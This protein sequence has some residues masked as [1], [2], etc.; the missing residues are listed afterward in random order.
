M[1]SERD[2]R[3]GAVDRRRT[4]SALAV[5]VALGLAACTQS[6]DASTDARRPQQA[7]QAVN[8][9]TIA[10]HIAAARGDVLIGDQ[11]AAQAQIKAATTDLT[12]SMRIP[13]V[14]RPIDHE[15]ARA[16]VRPIAGVRTSL[17]LDR[18]NFVVMV[19]AQQQRSMA[20]IDQVCLA[21]EPL[22]DTLAVVVNV[23]D[24]TAKTADGATTLSRNCQL[25]EGERAML[26][27]KREVDVVPAGLRA[28][29][30]AMQKR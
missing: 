10:S 25:I 14:S 23:Q 19:G 6:H 3:I 20:M 7:G 29:F 30:K 11:R 16:A 27:G 12:R 18:S 4:A 5:V 22:G 28:T 24:L 9:I 21:L 2:V 17:W 1:D 26:Q 13:D 15:A 8:P